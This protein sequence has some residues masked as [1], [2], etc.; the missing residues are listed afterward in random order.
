MERQTPEGSKQPHSI[1]PHIQGPN[2]SHE[3]CP[4]P[5]ELLA[6]MD[7]NFR[8]SETTEAHWAHLQFLA[9][10]QSQQALLG[11][12][13]SSISPF[14]VA[15]SSHLRSGEI[16]AE[17]IE[18]SQS[19]SPAPMLDISQNQYLLQAAQVPNNNN[20]LLPVDQFAQNTNEM[21]N[22]YHLP[23][24]TL[25]PEIRLPSSSRLARKQLQPQV[26]MP[27]GNLSDLRLINA[28]IA[29]AHGIS[30]PM[31]SPGIQGHPNLASGSNSFHHDGGSSSNSLYPFMSGQKK[32]SQ[33]WQR[34]S[35]KA[36]PNQ[37][38]TLEVPKTRAQN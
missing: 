9:S 27:L 25:P 32:H 36:T 15:H 26:S 20:V 24:S 30:Y 19:Q 14:D 5:E 31:R 18:L 3:L 38:S 29:H 17:N 23:L 6:N 4:L 13:Y 1:I 11:T 2:L 22:T 10:Q 12:L 37:K 33:G 34:G 35:L 28:D 21:L 8:S 7:V 16:I